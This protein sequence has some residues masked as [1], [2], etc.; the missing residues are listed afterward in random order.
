MRPILITSPRTGSNIVCDKLFNIARDNFSY[1]NNLYEFF[2]INKIVQS[3]YSIENNEI[4]CNLNVRVYTKWYQNKYE[5]QIDRL[6]LL[7]KTHGNYMI[8]LLSLDV[9][10]EVL[11]YIFS[12]YDPIFLERKDKI[13]QFCSWLVLY[14]AQRKAHNMRMRPLNEVSQLN[15]KK[16]YLTDFIFILQEYDRIKALHKSIFL[17]K[18]NERHYE[19]TMRRI[20]LFYEDIKYDVSEIRLANYLNLRCNNLKN[21]IDYFL[22]TPY[23]EA[24]TLEDLIDNQDEWQKDKPLLLD[25][26]NVNLK[27]YQARFI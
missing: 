14:T 16:D 26:Q 17:T 4:I 2:N 24:E 7:K 19:E 13:N 10:D 20:T 9:M 8:K 18:Y 15:Y 1:T 27:N 22:P 25:Y 11:E 3:L 5:L 12:N 23:A 6:N 21:Y